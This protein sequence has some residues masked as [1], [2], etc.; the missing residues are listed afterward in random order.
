MNLNSEVQ[1]LIAIKLAIAN[2]MA[3]T[4][5]VDIPK[6][7]RGRLQENL[8]EAYDAAAR[9]TEWIGGFDEGRN[10]KCTDHA[11]GTAD[12]RG[13]HHTERG[14]SEGARPQSGNWRFLKVGDT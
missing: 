4:K 7:I 5:R 8:K 3:F 14:F 10:C 2:M 9:L 13:A 11:C 6:D 1:D 12:H